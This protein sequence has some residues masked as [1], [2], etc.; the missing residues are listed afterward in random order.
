MSWCFSIEPGKFRG[1]YGSKKEAIDAGTEALRVHGGLLRIAEVQP[2]DVAKVFRLSASH[3]VL[4]FHENLS[5]MTYPG[6]TAGWPA[7]SSRQVKELQ[8][9]LDKTVAQWVEDNPGLLP[10]FYVITNGSDVLV[11]PAE[12]PRSTT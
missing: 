12:S 7:F 10:C 4:Q 1:K 6:A 11:R 3:A 8:A 2:V 5:A 9:L